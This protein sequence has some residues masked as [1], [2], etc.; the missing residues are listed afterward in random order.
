MT[1]I[2]A[3]FGNK[4][5]LIIGLYILWI[6]VFSVG[7]YQHEKQEIYADLDLRLQSAALTTPLL[8]ADGFHHQD[9]L[10]EGLSRNKD[11]TNIT[12][13]SNFTRHSDI[14]YIYS[15]IQKN[16]QILF[17]SSSATDEELDNNSGLSHFGD[18][19]DDVDPLV[20]AVFNNKEEAYIEY[21]DK[22]GHFRSVFIPITSEDGR[23]YV[24]GADLDISYIQDLLNKDLYTVLLIS[25]VFVLLAIPLVLAY[26][27]NTRHLADTLEKQVANRTLKLAISESKINSILEHSPVGI[28]HYDANSNLVTVNKQFEQLIGSTK[29]VLIGFNMLDN[30]V[31]EQMLDALRQSLSGQVGFYEGL[32]SSVTGHKDIYLQADFVPMFDSRGE[33]IGGVGVFNDITLRKKVEEKLQ[34]SAR[35]FSDTN[36]GITITNAEKEIIDV[37]P[38]FCRI[39]GYSREEV[40]GKNPRILSSGKQSPQFYVDMW[41]HIDEH[42]HWQGEVWNRTKKGELYAEL[43]NISTVSD[44][45][46]MIINY[47]GVF[48]DITRSKNQQEKLHQMA[49]YDVLTQLPNRT[50]FADRFQQ[51][52]AHSKRNATQIAV[53]FLDLDKFKPINDTYGHMVGDELLKE[54]AARIKLIIRD[55]DTISRQ[56]GDEFALLLGGIE[57]FSHCEQFLDRLLEAIAQPYRINGETHSISASCGITLY[58]FDNA[59]LDTLLRHADHA[60]YQAKQ[61]GRNRHHLFS[62]E[63]DAFHTQKQQ[64]LDEINLALINN[65]FSLYYQPKVNMA[66]GE[67]FGAEALIRWHHPDRGL[68]QPLEFLPIIESTELEIKVGDWVINEALSQLEIWHRQDIRPEVSINISSHHLQSETF[69]TQLESALALHPTVNSQCLQ[70]E[71]LESSALGDLDAIS[72]IIQ[73]CQTI[74]GVNIALDDFGTGYSSLTHLRSLSAD[75]IKIDQSFV[76]DILDDPSDYSIIDGIIG[77][78][79]S[80]NRGLIAEGV[81]TTNHGLVLLMMGCDE[82]QGYGIAKPMPAEDIP[83][84]IQHYSPNQA[85]LD[86][87]RHQQT[88]QQNKLTIFRIITEHWKERFINNIKS[89]AQTLESWPIMNDTQCPCGKWIQRAIQVQLFDQAALEQLAMSHETI[90]LQAHALLLQFQNGEIDSARKGLAEFQTA[91]DNMEKN[92]D[93]CK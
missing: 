63:D 24:V 92:L 40:M 31:D 76:R 83:Q 26:S 18:I 14:V 53:C 48:T 23:T 66:T 84:W 28:F 43:L 3:V 69:F 12:K 81:E 13:L 90:H 7:S 35:V 36:E 10:K 42:G 71:I 61:A 54:V 5:Y 44:D 88:A 4:I 32:Y 62:V 38:A 73:Q 91:F 65:E 52:V 58:P 29:D 17:T 67:V 25:T 72:Y 70:L 2:H 68:I 49:H 75:T 15:L 80:F 16:G 85:W 57:S 33:I 55:E 22:W 34:L 60:M 78:A 46:G 27:K 6:V 41:Q 89:S 30:L 50:L 11:I 1:K 37:N 56:G 9:M 64:Q 87:S 47:V 20:F 8:L 39:T 74:L 51:A 45:H 77:L 86:H 82:A 19:Y 93:L 59:D 79:D 21:K